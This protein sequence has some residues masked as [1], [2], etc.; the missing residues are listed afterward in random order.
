MLDSLFVSARL[1]LALYYTVAIVLFSGSVSGLFYQRT[2]GVIER[3]YDRLELRLQH[4]MEGFPAQ[5]R[6]QSSRRILLAD[7]ET[8]KKLVATQLIRINILISVVTAVA[9]YILAGLTLSPIQ[10]AMQEQK[11]FIGDA[12]HE[13]KTPITA[14]KTS[15]EVNLLDTKISKGTKQ[16]LMENLEDLAHLENLSEGLLRLARLEEEPVVLEPIQLGIALSQLHRRFLPTAKQKGLSFTLDTQ[17]NKKEKLFVLGTDALLLELLSIFVDNAIKYTPTGAVTV[18][19]KKVRTGVVVEISDTGIGIPEDVRGHIFDRF[20]QANEA[21]TQCSVG[22]HGLGLA[23]AKK[24]LAQLGAQVSM[25]STV[26]SGTRFFL[27]FK[28]A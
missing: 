16:I 20:Y 15:L 22:G 14:L 3:E 18:R 19:Y 4:E 13:L 25:Q 5:L 10:K 26:K 17:E 27:T 24:I 28:R 23:V 21:R 6:Q 1:K 2:A 11:R 8:A 12:A 7:I 9:G